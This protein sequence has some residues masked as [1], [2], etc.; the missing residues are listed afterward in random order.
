MQV[1]RQGWFGRIQRH[2]NIAE[3]SREPRKAIGIG[4]GLMR[5]AIGIDG[6]DLVDDFMQARDAAAAAAAKPA[7]T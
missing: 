5:A 6:Q 2:P 7:S 1:L 3:L 4:A